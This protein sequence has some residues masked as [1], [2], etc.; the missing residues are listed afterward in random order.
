MT[1][2]FIHNEHQLN[3]YVEHL[4]LKLAKDGR[5]KVSVKSAKTRTLT[6]NKSIHKYCAMLSEAFNE[7][8][9]DMEKVL[10]KGTSIPWSESKVKEDIWRTV[11]IAAIDK[12]ST[13]DLDTA[14][15]GKVYEIINRHISETF[16]LFIP[17]PCKDNMQ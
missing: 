10:A 14:E 9:L 15:V 12:V 6:Q 4:K 3:A 1:D 11:Q 8:G 17:W 2:T 7:A 5:L 13:T 16:G